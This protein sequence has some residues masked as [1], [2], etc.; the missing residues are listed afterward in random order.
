MRIKIQNRSFFALFLTLV[1]IATVGCSQKSEQ[2]ETL[3]RYS[4][5]R[6]KEL[7]GLYFYPS[8]IRMLSKILGDENGKALSEIK[9]GR[10]FFSWNDNDSHV[11][12][13]MDGFKSDLSEEGFE[14][15]MQMKSSGN[16]IDVYLLDRDID[17]YVL[18]VD[19]EQGT[20][21]LEIFGNLSNGTIRSLSEL[22]M[23]K[24]TEVFDL[25]GPELE[26]KK[27]STQTES[28]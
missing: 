16:K 20:F 17:D 25:N 8:T 12:E 28:N 13:L 19:G 14:M 21:I 4:K 3:N 27:D 5:T 6:D 18:F 11:R 7:T 10:I 24:V 26:S 9:R 22:D 2:S 1:F 15:L 23:S